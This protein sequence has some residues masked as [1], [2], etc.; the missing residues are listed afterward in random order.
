MTISGISSSSSMAYGPSTV[1]AQAQP[2]GDQVSMSFSADTFSSLVNEAG[3]MPDVRGEVVDAF[4][5]RIQSGQYPSPQTLDGVADVMGDH[6]P[7]FAS[8]GAAGASGS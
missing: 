3:Q 5:A 2:A 4:K 1:R 6:W 8:D 7:Q